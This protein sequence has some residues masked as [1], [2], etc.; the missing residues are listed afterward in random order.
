M[1]R[2][3]AIVSGPR[4]GGKTTLCRRL[5][6]LARQRGLDCAGIISPAHFEGGRKV[7]IDLLDARSGERRPLAK[8]DGLPGE[9]R[10]VAFRFDPGAVEWGVGLLNAACPCDVLIVDELGPLELERGQGWTNALDVLRNGLFK[11]AVVVVRPALVSVFRQS[12]SGVPSLSEAEL[13]FALPGMNVNK[14]SIRVMSRLSSLT[15]SFTPH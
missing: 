13:L 15:R 4:G 7:G 9:L 10:T 8:A 14:K 3:L 2:Q 5:L 1:P 12:M 6:E 11:L